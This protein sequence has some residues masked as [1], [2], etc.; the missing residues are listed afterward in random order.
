MDTVE[1]AF[2]EASSTDIRW[3]E[4]GVEYDNSQYSGEVTVDLLEQWVRTHLIRSE[5]LPEPQEGDSVPVV[6]QTFEQLVLQPDKDVFL[7]IYASW[8][9]Y[10]R[11]FMPAWEGL[12]RRLRHVPNLVL[13]KMDGDRNGSPYPEDFSW[14]AYPTVF[15]IKAGTR[16]PVVFHGN[17]TEARLLSFLK[18]NGSREMVRALEE[19]LASTPTS[20]SG[21]VLESDWEL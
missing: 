16:K 21:G 14:H 13:A 4:E 6:G 15:F 5:P 12:A 9:G 18:E 17:R 19:A 7:L 11:K 8:C 2:K 20:E 3:L 1:F 10:S